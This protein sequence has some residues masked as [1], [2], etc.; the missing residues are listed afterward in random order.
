MSFVSLL[1]VAVG[2]SMDAFA[3]A[4]CKGM[5]MKRLD[6]RQA[7]LIALF[8]GAFQM[9]MPLAGWLLG[10]QFEMYITHIDHWVAF[11]LLG[12]IGG[13]M[14]WEALRGC[15]EDTPSVFSIKELFMLAIAT[16]IDA[17]AAGI[18]FSFLHVDALPASVMIGVITF[19]LSFI[20]VCTGK[21]FGAMLHSK[22][23]LAGGIILI[24]L[25]VKIVLEHTGVIG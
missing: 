19:A 11:V 10:S 3:V 20:G 23:E 21:R 13:H 24:L 9:L 5:R 2:L 25:G 18:S 22:A 12:L 16:S 6:V 14:I 17:L 1:L 7:A 4:L 15:E 8:F